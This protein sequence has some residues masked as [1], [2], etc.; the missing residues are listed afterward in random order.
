[1]NDLFREELMKKHEDKEEE[2]KL[3]K[4]KKEDY[5]RIKKLLDKEEEK[6]RSSPEE[7][8]KVGK[9][10]GNLKLKMEKDKIEKADNQKKNSS[11][12]VKGE[13]KK[14][15]TRILAEVEDSQVLLIS[16]LLISLR[17]CRGKRSGL[18]STFSNH[19]WILSARFS[20]PAILLSLHQLLRYNS[21]YFIFKGLHDQIMGY[22]E[23]S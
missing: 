5:E 15:P 2:R 7:E 19:T 22:E 21:F 23:D 14:Q 6:G 17:W 9:K 11:E 8:T 1:M 3:E 20:L 16:Y 4:E 13:F 10:A 12:E 18:L